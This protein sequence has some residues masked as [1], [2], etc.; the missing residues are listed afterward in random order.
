MSPLGQTNSRWTLGAIVFVVLFAYIGV[1]VAY[2]ASNTNESTDTRSPASDG[3]LV[4]LDIG[5]VDG[6]AFSVGATVS[7]YPG[8]DLLTSE[9][10]L[11]NQLTVDL[12]P[13]ASES[14]LVFPA[15]TEISPSTAT[16]YSDGDI[17]AWPF[18]S[19]RAQS[20]V[21]RASTMVDSEPVSVPTV[22]AVTNSL[23]G[24]NIDS[25][26]QDQIGGAGFDVTVSRNVVSKV[27]DLAICVVLLALPMCALFVAVNTVRGRKK[28]QPPMVTWFAV[29]LFA[30]LPIR[31]LLPGAPPIGSW[32]DYSVVLWVVLGLVTAMILYV[33]TWW[34][35][36][37]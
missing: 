6:A 28:F 16:I 4:Y 24:W 8:E 35:D 33:Y 36:A 21:V 9:G 12:S 25:G 2:G 3:L 27:Y 14:R 22:V 10:Y 15:G 5:S 32:V 1:L 18:D 19:Y 37:P 26:A 34:R 17:R 13:L 23:T 29:M 30:V 7:V 20:V 31:N 11:K